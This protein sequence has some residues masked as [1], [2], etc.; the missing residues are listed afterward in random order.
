MIFP[1][2]QFCAERFIYAQTT[3]KAD[4]TMKDIGSE[5]YNKKQSSAVGAKGIKNKNI[6]F[7]YPL[8]SSL[9]GYAFCCIL[10]NV[11]QS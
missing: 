9:A 8:L 3:K 5:E 1:S 4:S 6:I 7:V 2:S 10:S 11:Y